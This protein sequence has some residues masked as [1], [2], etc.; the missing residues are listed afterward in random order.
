MLIKAK[1]TEGSVLKA[2]FI[3]IN[4]GILVL[5]LIWEIFFGQCSLLRKTA[6]LVLFRTRGAAHCTYI[7]SPYSCRT[8]SLLT[9]TLPLPAIVH[10]RASVFVVTPCIPRTSVATSAVAPLVVMHPFIRLTIL[11]KHLSH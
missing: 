6:P 3:T 9:V 11:L 5:Y 7:L 1:T 4:V 10:Y 8:V 2:A